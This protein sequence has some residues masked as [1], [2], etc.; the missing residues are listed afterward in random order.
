ML[1][2]MGIPFREHRL[3]STV[4]YSNIKKKKKKKKKPPTKAQNH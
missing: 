1:R 2:R 3:E 4:R